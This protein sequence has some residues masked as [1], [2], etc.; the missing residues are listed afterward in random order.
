VSVRAA[1]RTEEGWIFG[2]ESEVKNLDTASEGWGWKTVRD[3]LTHS[4]DG[5]FLYRVRLIGKIKKE[6]G[7]CP[8]RGAGSVTFLVF[9]AASTRTEFVA[10]DLRLGAHRFR[11]LGISQVRMHLLE[12]ALRSGRGSEQLL[13]F[14]R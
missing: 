14:A 1:N 8:L 6:W 9:L 5:L 12:S 10:P 7:G 13:G 4:I 3:A 11:R 2:E